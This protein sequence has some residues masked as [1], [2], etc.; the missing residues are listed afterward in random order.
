MELTV[1]VNGKT[2]IYRTLQSC[3][4]YETIQGT[5]NIPQDNAAVSLELHVQAEAEFEVYLDEFALTSTT[6]P[7]ENLAYFVDCGDHEPSTLADGEKFGLYNSVTDQI[8]GADPHTGKTWGV[9]DYLDAQGFKASDS[10]GAYTKYTQPEHNGG[11]TDK[12]SKN[13]TYRYAHGQDSSQDVC[14]LLYTSDAADE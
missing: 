11:T 14:C 3:E 8:Y 9:Y 4:N 6:I 5:L 10:N 13:D 7:M 2:N 12:T 1:T